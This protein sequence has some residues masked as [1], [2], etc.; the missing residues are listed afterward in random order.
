MMVDGPEMGV[1]LAKGAA[2]DG[3]VTLMDGIV[4]GDC[5]CDLVGGGVEGEEFNV[6]GMG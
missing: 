1:V 6:R 5:L 3:G 4:D 2:D